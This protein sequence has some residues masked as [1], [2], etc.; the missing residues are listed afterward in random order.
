MAPTNKEISEQFSAG[1]FSFCYP[2]FADEVEWKIVGNKSV[3]DRENV[4]LN[5]NK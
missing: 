3:K 4:I 2:Y 1:N 5:A